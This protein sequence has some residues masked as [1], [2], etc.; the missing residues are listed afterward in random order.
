MLIML[1]YCCSN[2]RGGGGLTG[3]TA[4]SSIPP[5]PTII[6]TT[7]TPVLAVPSPRSRR[8]AAQR[9]KKGLARTTSQRIINSNPTMN[10]GDNDDDI[11]Q[12]IKDERQQ[13]LSPRSFGDGNSSNEIPHLE[14]VESNGSS[15][16]K[17]NIINNINNNNNNNNKIFTTKHISKIDHNDTLAL[18]QTLNWSMVQNTSRRNVIRTDD[19]N[20][21]RTLHSNKP[22]CQSFIFGTNMKDPNGALSYWTITYPVIYKRLCQLINKYDPN[23]TFTHITVNKN[24]CCARH[25][26][27]GNVGLSYIAGFGSYAGGE[28][29]IEPS[30]Q[31]QHILLPS[32]DDGKVIDVQQDVMLDLKSKFVLFDGKAQSHETLPFTGGD[33]YTLVY[34]TSDMG[35]C[36]NN[37][38]KKV[39]Q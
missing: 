5:S 3:V 36:T 32:G 18:L 22:Y 1:W 37:N 21:P 33:R 38:N 25:T 28:L 13:L 23:F 29:L 9:A 15:D 26:D 7:T 12:R 10:N 4:F 27:G 30:P 14:G 20:T 8:K 17:S 6:T 31:K 24:L 34:Y 11:R 16:A 39:I 19:P 2:L 35:R